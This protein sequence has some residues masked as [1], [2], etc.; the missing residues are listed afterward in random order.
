MRKPTT[1]RAIRPEM[2]A[3]VLPAAQSP[4]RLGL[5]EREGTQDAQRVFLMCFLCSFRTWLRE[6]VELNAYPPPIP[7]FLARPLRNK[8]QK[9]SRIIHHYAV[10]ELV[11]HTRGLQF[12]HENG[13]RLR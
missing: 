9:P 11:A 12:R 13:H 4:S 3:I 6:I 5:T 8:R 1:S 10:Q 7:L 2:P